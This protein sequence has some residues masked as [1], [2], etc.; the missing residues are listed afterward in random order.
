MSVS[1]RLEN[2]TRASV[3]SY[4]VQKKNKAK[5]VFIKTVLITK[6]T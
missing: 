1:C 3:V 2:L 5:R 6:I 4:C